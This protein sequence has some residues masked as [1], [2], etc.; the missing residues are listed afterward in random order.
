MPAQKSNNQKEI[1]AHFATIAECLCDLEELVKCNSVAI[2]DDVK[3]ITK[4]AFHILS[5]RVSSNLQKIEQLLR[6]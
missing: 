2:T 5:E 1:E 4:G 3:S 6:R